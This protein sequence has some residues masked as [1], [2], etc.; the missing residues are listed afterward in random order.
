MVKLDCMQAMVAGYIAS[1]QGQEAVRKFLAS[2][3]G[4][5]AIDAYLATPE[6][7][8]MG[9]F[10][11]ARALDGLDLPAPVREQVRTALAENGG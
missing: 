11:L 10:I 6:G 3:E 8:K 4:Q 9:R 1:P 2:P 7:R 5:R